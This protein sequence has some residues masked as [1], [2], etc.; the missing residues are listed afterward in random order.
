[1]VSNSWPARVLPGFSRPANRQ[2]VGVVAGLWL[3]GSQD[4]EVL[5]ACEYRLASP[6]L[7]IGNVCCIPTPSPCTSGARGET[8]RFWCQLR[9][10]PK[11][12]TLSGKRHR[13]A[14]RRC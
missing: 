9:L 1:M 2:L 3:G 8:V 14:L 13:D 10:E 5:R 12:P 7:L 11:A 6:A 4:C